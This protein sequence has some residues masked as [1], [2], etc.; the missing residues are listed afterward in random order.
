[1]SV[2]KKVG[3]ILDDAKMKQR[4]FDIPVSYFEGL[5]N[6]VSSKIGKQEGGGFVRILKPAALLACS[7]LFVFFIGYGILSLTGTSGQDIKDAALAGNSTVVEDVV[8]EEEEAIIEYL[9][10]NISLEAIHEYINTSETDNDTS[11]Q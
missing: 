1:M 7:F 3:D 2:M 11:N 4:A 5:E 8:D 10:Q 6:R 9:A